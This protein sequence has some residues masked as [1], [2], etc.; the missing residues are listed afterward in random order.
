MTQDDRSRN[1]D[2][3]R[4]TSIVWREER[5]LAH[6]DTVKAILSLS[7]D[8]RSAEAILRNPTAREWR[9]VAQIIAEQG[10]NI[11]ELGNDDALELNVDRLAWGLLWGVSEG[12]LALLG[13]GRPARTRPR[14]RRAHASP[15]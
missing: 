10:Q 7:S 15:E 5:T 1:S 6:P 2:L 8:Q 13:T 11:A 9:R 3:S 14:R 12:A 4:I